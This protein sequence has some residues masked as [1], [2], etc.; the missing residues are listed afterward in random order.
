MTTI[1]P[2]SPPESNP[3]TQ[4]V[5]AH[6]EAI[7]R[8]LEQIPGFTFP[9]Q[10]ARRK[11]N[12]TASVPDQFL[13]AVA[14]AIEASPALAGA[15]QTTA[16]DLRNAIAFERAFSSLADDLE[17]EA[18]AVRY[19]IAN[20]RSDAGRFALQ[21]YFMA[22]GLNRPTDRQVLVPHLAKMAKALGR[23]KIGGGTPAP[24]TPPE[25]GAA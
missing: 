16:N 9:A 7:R 4:Q 23:R 2:E 14:M 13:E 11:I 3:Y 19:T 15:A 8:I 12:F 17:V 18:H 22:K 10:G 25:G 5:R 24:A 6:M 1:P 21:A 20:T